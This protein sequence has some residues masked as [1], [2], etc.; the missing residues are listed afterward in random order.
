VDTG[1]I[2]AFGGRGQAGTLATYESY[3]PVADAWTS[4]GAMPEALEGCLCLH[5]GGYLKIFGGERANGTLSD[6]IWIYHPAEN[7]WRRG[8]RLPYAARDLFGYSVVRTWQHRGASQT[9][10]FSFLGGG[11]DGTGHRDEVFRYFSR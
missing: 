8:G 5:E 10:E 1:R 11:H 7:H 3:D 9:D 2:Y 4:L 6:E